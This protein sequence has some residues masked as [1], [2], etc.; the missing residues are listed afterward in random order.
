MAKKKTATGQSFAQ[1][2]EELEKIVASFDDDTLDVDE[3]LKQF[4]KGLKL[5]ESLKKSL[6]GVE[7]KID[8][9]KQKYHVE[10]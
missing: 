3:S 7:N 5:A 1:Q 9:L 10:D 8:S 4:E 6:E 2:F